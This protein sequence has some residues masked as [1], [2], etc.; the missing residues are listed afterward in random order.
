MF[1]ERFFT[2]DADHNEVKTDSM[3]EWGKWFEDFDNRLIGSYGFEKNGIAVRYS[4]ICF[5]MSGYSRGYETAIIINGNFLEII[6][7]NNYAEALAF[8]NDLIDKTIEYVY[9]KLSRYRREVKKYQRM[10]KAVC[11]IVNGVPHYNI[12]LI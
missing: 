6:K 1:S 9:V 11:C 2:L 10:V 8:H 5:G 4:T 12:P 3:I 7:H